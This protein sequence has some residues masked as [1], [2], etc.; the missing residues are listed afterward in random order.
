MESYKNTS[1]TTWQN[2]CRNSFWP[3][4][5]FSNCFFLRTKN[6]CVKMIEVKNHLI[7]R[8]QTINSKKKKTMTETWWSREWVDGNPAGATWEHVSWR[9][10]NYMFSCC[11]RW[12]SPPI[13]HHFLDWDFFFQEILVIRFYSWKIMVVYLCGEWWYVQNFLEYNG[14]QG[15]IYWIVLEAT[16]ISTNIWKSTL[17]LIS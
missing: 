14:V 10:I 7:M 15:R 6:I 9:C 4:E 3:V 11:P 17:R 12:T 8:K 1:S 16:I 2:I 5:L 13:S